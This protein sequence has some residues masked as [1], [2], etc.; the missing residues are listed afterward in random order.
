MREMIVDGIPLR[1]P[2]GEWF[3][4]YTQSKLVADVSR[5]FDSDPPYGYHGNPQNV[6]DEAY[7][8]VGTETWVLN[9]IGSS[10]ADFEVN[11][12]GILGLVQRPELTVLGAPQFSGL[13]AGSARVGQTFNVSADLVTQAKMRMI[14]SPAKKRIGPDA[15]ELTLIME[16]LWAFWMSRDYFTSAMT[17]L[18][19]ASQAIVLDS[20]MADSS[21][22]VTDG[23][24]RI[25]GPIAAGGYVII[26]DRA[27]PFRAIRYSAVTA[28]GASEYV[29]I[30]MGTLAARLQT[31]DTWAMTGGTD[32]G[33]RATSAGDGAF[34]MLGALGANW[35]AG[36]YNYTVT[37]VSS[38]YTSGSTAVGFRV[39][40]SYLA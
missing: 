3:I 9:V 40:R 35:P 10:K 30:D 12:R 17:A 39:R 37:C 7:F 8:G 4:D 11:L 32:V 22:P 28:L 21:S 34:Y 23:L 25:K 18:T 19:S 5:E 36:P 13:N 2:L 26:Q 6:V 27:N 29:V 31:T 14:G 1:D 38:G 33:S 16:N 20:T 15:M 24:V